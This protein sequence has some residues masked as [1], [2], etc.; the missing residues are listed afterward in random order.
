MLLEH[1]VDL[2]TS[3]NL[4]QGAET[5]LHI[6]TTECE[7]NSISW[8]AE[9]GAELK[10]C[11]KDDETVYEIAERQDNLS[12]QTFLLE[13][14]AKLTDRPHLWKMKRLTRQHQETAEGFNHTAAQLRRSRR[15]VFDYISKGTFNYYDLTYARKLLDNAKEEMKTVLGQARRSN[16]EVIFFVL[17]R[18]ISPDDAKLKS[19]RLLKAHPARPQ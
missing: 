10:K 12:L 11:N 3:T 2:N 5:P 15:Q 8:L 9:K 6:A 19:F 16:L 14:E 18:V 13:L 17:E 1:V 4:E 7:P